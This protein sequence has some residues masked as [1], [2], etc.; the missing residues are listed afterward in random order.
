[1]NEARDIIDEER[2]DEEQRGPCPYEDLGDPYLTEEAVN[3]LDHTHLYHFEDFIIHSHPPARYAEVRENLRATIFLLQYLQST[4]KDTSIRLTDISMIR[5]Y[6][7]GVI[8]LSEEMREQFRCLEEEIRKNLE[9]VTI[10]EA[11]LLTSFSKKCPHATAREVIA[12]MRS[13]VLARLA[14]ERE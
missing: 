13:H 9:S 14:N 3:E 10:D 2:P 11:L 8:E 5:R 7:E 1:M 12:G 6:I 4:P